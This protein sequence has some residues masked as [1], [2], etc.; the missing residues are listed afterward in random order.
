MRAQT[1]DSDVDDV[2]DALLLCAASDK[3]NGE[4]YNLGCEDPLTLEKLAQT[5]IDIAGQGEYKK[6]DFPEDRKSIDIGDYYADYRKIRARIGWKPEV[7]I[8]EGLRRTIA[9]YAE[10]TERYWGHDE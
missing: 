10:N 2:V 8:K 4:I 5:M 3:T 6:I 7:S 1:L 9:Y